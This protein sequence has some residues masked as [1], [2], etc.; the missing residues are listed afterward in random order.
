MSQFMWHPSVL[1]ALCQKSYASVANGGAAYVM[2]VQTHMTLTVLTAMNT[3]EDVV[4]LDFTVIFF[5]SSTLLPGGNNLFLL[6]L[7]QPMV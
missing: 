6:S 1:R 3:C 7:L 2:S 5:L 4:P